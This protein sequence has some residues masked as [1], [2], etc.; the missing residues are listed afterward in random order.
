[1]SVPKVWH[2]PLE[3][4]FWDFSEGSWWLRKPLAQQWAAPSEA[5][6]SYGWR[7]R[8]YPANQMYIGGTTKS[9]YLNVAWPKESVGH[10]IWD[11]LIVI[12][13]PAS[14]ATGN[15][16]RFLPSL[17][18]EGWFLHR[19]GKP[20]YFGNV[21]RTGA[22]PPGSFIYTGLESRFLHVASGHSFLASEVAEKMSRHLFANKKRFM[23]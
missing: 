15:V 21:S 9:C 22:V 14:V 16:R 20:K 8:E 19:V 2:V 4:C 7:D 3:R 6:Q 23:L 5:L 13:L 1:M 12:H 10:P 17:G 18:K 11:N